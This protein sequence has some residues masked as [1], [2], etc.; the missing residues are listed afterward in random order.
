MPINLVEDWGKVLISRD[1]VVSL[2][3]YLEQPL[4]TGGNFPMETHRAEADGVDDLLAELRKAVGK[5]AAA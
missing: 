3:H 4:R 5:E 2:V 1:L